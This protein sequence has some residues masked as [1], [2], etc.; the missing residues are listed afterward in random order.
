MKPLRSNCVPA[1]CKIGIMTLVRSLATSGLKQALPTMETQ[2]SH[3]SP[4][5]APRNAPTT[6]YLPSNA[7][8]SP[9]AVV[10]DE[11]K[12]QSNRYLFQERQV[13]FPVCGSAKVSPY[14]TLCCEEG[15]YCTTVN[16]IPSCPWS[17]TAAP[18]G[19]SSTSFASTQVTQL[20]SSQTIDSSSAT[21]GP[22]STSEEPPTTA[23][24]LTVIVATL[25]TSAFPTQIST[26]QSSSA[27]SDP[28]T[29]TTGSNPSSSSLS[30][31]FIT[32]SSSS[33]NVG[34]V[35]PTHTPTSSSSTASSGLS[36]SGQIALGVIVPIGIGVIAIIAAT[37]IKRT[38]R[39][40]KR[41]LFCCCHCEEEG[42]EHGPEAHEMGNFPKLR[43]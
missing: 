17:T 25:I 27:A 38:R 31:S 20:P 10:V 15:Q 42:E 28:Q 13:C 36:T 43:R 22:F 18:Q 14:I 26:R 39:L 16:G 5:S 23:P 8:L 7:S 11:A 4:Y 33:L 12:S 35:T 34:S 30:S 37:F 21:E 29:S 2:V 3:D 6:V 40:M 41:Y 19:F 9:S 1:D 32:S 24:A